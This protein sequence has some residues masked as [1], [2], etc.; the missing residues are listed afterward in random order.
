MHTFIYPNVDTELTIRDQANRI[1]VHDESS[2]NLTA[3]SA[4]AHLRVFFGQSDAQPGGRR[5]FFAD[6]GPFDTDELRGYL[7][8]MG[9][10]TFFFDDKFGSGVT[11][12]APGD[13]NATLGGGLG[14]NFSEHWGAEIQLVNSEPNINL[15]GIGKFAEFSNFSVLPMVRFRWPFLGGRLVPYLSAGVGVTFNDINDARSTIDEFGVAGAVRA[16]SVEVTETSVA[17]SVQLGVEYFLN[18][19][20]SFGIGVPAYIYPDWDTEVRFNSTRGPNGA[21]LPR[22]VQHDSMNFTSIGGLLQIKVYLP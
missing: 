18:H 19:H 12:E 9:G 6:H 5:L 11:L 15:S 7:Y 22:G 1:V 21:P 8:F 4:L 13:F 14:L 3:V 20:L 2:V 10:D 17:G 16:P